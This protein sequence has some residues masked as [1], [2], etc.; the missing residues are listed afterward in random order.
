MKVLVDVSSLIKTCLY[1]GKDP[2]AILASD[3]SQVNSARWGYD[4]T[5]NSLVATLDYLKCVPSDIV[6][7]VEGFHSKS[8]RQHI[9]KGYKQD[10]KPKAPEMFEQ[11]NEA[12]ALVLGAFRKLGSVQVSQDGV[13]ADD[14]IAWF[15]THT[16]EDTVIVSND[17]DLCQ[18][19]GPNAHGANIAVYRT[20]GVQR[21]NPYGEFSPKNILVYKATVGDSSDKIKGVPGFGPAK[22]QALLE[23]FGDDGLTELRRLGDEGSLKELYEQAG[24]EP[25]VKRLVDAE[26]NYLTSFRLA[27]LYPEWCNTLH[28]PLVWTPG[29]V[30]G[31]TEDLRLKKW[32]SKMRLVTD[33]NFDEACKFLQ[34]RMG[35]SPGFALDL[36]TST[37]DESD[38]WLEMRRRKGSKSAGVDVISSRITGGSI[39]FGKNGQYS[40]YITV[41][42]ADSDNVSIEQFGY[43]IS[44]LDKSKLTVAHNAAGFELPVLFNQFGNAWKD[45]GWRGMFPNMVDSRIAA[46]FWDE[47]QNSFGL[48]NLSKLLLNYEQETYEQVTGGLKMNQVSAERVLSYGCDDVITSMALWNYFKL[49]MELE[50]TFEAFMRIEQKP[51]YLQALA[52]TQ[53]VNVDMPRLA[54]LT[55]KDEE[56][57]G[58]LQAKLDTY[59]VE[60]GWDGTVLPVYTEITAASIKQVVQL[61][62]T[63][64]TTMVRTPSKLVPLIAALNVPGA[65]HLAAIVESGSVEDFNRFVKLHWTAKPMLNTGS[66][67]Q[68]QKLLFDTIGMPV[69]LRNKPTD[70]M[71]AKGI[72]EG[73]PRTDED[74]IVMAIKLGDVSDKEAEVLRALVELK[75]ISTRRGL[76]W[77]AYP[78][79]LHW[80]TGRIHP[81]LRQSAT[82]TRRYAGSNPN[83]QQMDSNPEGVRSVI[84]PHHRKAVILSLDE[85]AQ[86]VRQL[87][88]Y[89][90][91]ANLL[92]CYL[93]S[94]DQL[95]DVHSIVAC[96][97]A[98]CSY[99]EF[100]RRLKKGSDDEQVIANAQRQKAKITLFAS[101]YGAAAPKIA[102]GLGIPTEEAQG[103]IDAIYE[104]FPGVAAWKQASEDMATDKGFV[105]IHGGTIRHLAQM[106]MSEDKYAAS[107]ALRQAG[108]ARIQSAGGNQ[109][110]TVMSRIWDSNLLDDYDYRWMFSIHDETVHSIGVE[111]V[112][113]VTKR[114][115][116]FM[117]EQFLEVVPSASSI[118]VGR[119]FGKLNELGEV[120]DAEKLRK[121]VDEI[122]G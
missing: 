63:E 38:D 2:E 105:P 85:S 98:G 100:R 110:K 92:T 47:N 59:L 29:M 52:Y 41:D 11:F 70:T 39:L 23:R 53:G 36:E 106:I 18:L 67:L 61:L 45:N 19:L 95:R 1:A 40:Y 43:L 13:E 97:I 104:Q 12:K 122:F 69:R 26:E 90:R 60:Q 3:G 55:R 114:L 46:S 118:G 62:G 17:G 24:T 34:A 111:H 82:N 48:K 50:G 7:A 109:I 102:E 20:H 75:S 73:T 10:T 77:E 96:K 89:A 42:H 58:V 93:G 27:K 64:L 113:E 81:E 78:K 15:C 30:A 54:E 9:D 74:A 57:G 32:E 33:S 116:E 25:L 65:D 4:N 112:V 121:A 8:R 94:P 22:F 117:C 84:L 86:E 107:K 119:N 91:D 99:E 120:F 6:F 5:V 87:A 31:S 14:I 37:P 49:F 51:M 108:N 76:Y 115:H 16:K 44:L 79:A 68:L 21:E 83:L 80:E 35:E 88:D 28:Q 66:P 72:R 71:R 101:I 103:Y 56:L